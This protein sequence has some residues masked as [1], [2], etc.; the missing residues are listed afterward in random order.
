MAATLMLLS[1][2]KEDATSPRGPYTG[3]YT[4]ERYSY[5]I[6]MDSS[7]NTITTTDTSACSLLVAENYNHTQISVRLGSYI[8]PFSSASVKS[9]QTA[10]CLADNPSGPPTTLKITVNMLDLYIHNSNPQYSI[11][12]CKRQP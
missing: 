3:T 5:S 12:H 6:S 8:Y 4:G 2:K 11:Y 9:G 1:C 10:Y 7:G